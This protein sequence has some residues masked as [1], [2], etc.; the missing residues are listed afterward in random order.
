VLVL[1]AGDDYLDAASMPQALGRTAFDIGRHPEYLWHYVGSGTTEQREP[2]AVVRGKVLGGSGA[3]NAAN[4]TRNVPEDFDA[5]GSTLWNF[6][7]VLPFFRKLEADQDFRGEAHGNDGPIPV[8]RYSEDKWMPFQAGFYN[9]ALARGFSE[10]PDLNHFDGSG[11]GP[12]PR[13]DIIGLRVNSAIAYLNPVR[14]RPNLRVLPR[15]RVHKLLIRGSRAVGLQSLVDGQLHEIEADEIILS[16]GGLESPHLL[17][18]SGIGPAQ[19]LKELGIPVVMDLPGVGE[20][21]TDHGMV[22]VQYA[23]VDGHQTWTSTLVDQ[24]VGLIF[25]ASQSPYRNDLRLQPT[26]AA[27]EDPGSSLIAKAWVTCVLD[28]PT[29]TGKLKVRSADPLVAPR[30]EF[31]Y[32]GTPFDVVRMRDAVRVAVRIVD[33][34]HDMQASYK[35]LAPLDDDLASDEPLDRWLLA[36]IRTGFHSCGTARMGNASDSM[37]VVDERCRV[38][39]IEGLRVADLSIAPTVGRAS[40]HPTALMIGERVSD[41]I[42]TEGRRLNQ[43]VAS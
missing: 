10:K 3:V 1:E 13:N 12:L 26:L 37:A 16:A 5:W 40:M 32:L 31:R 42:L 14:I 9:S 41:L 30:I 19:E 18:L 20:N 4:F 2:L 39:G 28:R 15:H 38:L 29:S 35:R 17:M 43:S 6:K 36:N 7:A 23:S 11:V 25:T 22:H 27:E 21:L 24:T 33:D 8:G 34:D